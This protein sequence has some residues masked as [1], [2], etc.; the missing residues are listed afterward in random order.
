MNEK[1][2]TYISSF[3]FSVFMDIF[4]QIYCGGSKTAFV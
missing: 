3:F 1:Q 4:T 2:P